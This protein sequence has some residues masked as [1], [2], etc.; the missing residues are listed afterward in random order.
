M[1]HG[2][3][4]GSASLSDDEEGGFRMVMSRSSHTMRVWDRVSVK[5]R[6]RLQNGNE[7][8]QPHDESL[9]HVHEECQYHK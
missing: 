9:E 5:I 3:L 4:A 2:C 7:P 1:R 6:V 8:L